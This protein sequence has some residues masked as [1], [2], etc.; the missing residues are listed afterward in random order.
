MSE[1]TLIK[2]HIETNN[3]KLNYNINFITKYN[4]ICDSNESSNIY[5]KEILHVFNI[6]EYDDKKIDKIQMELFKDMV[7]TERLKNIMKILAN[8]YFSEDLEFGFI[9]LFSYDYFYITHKCISSFYKK[10]YIEEE[11][12]IELEDKVRI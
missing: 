8:S 10:G 7:K 12:L 9:I 11:L 3:E 4:V 1:Q 2:S 5:K 6:D